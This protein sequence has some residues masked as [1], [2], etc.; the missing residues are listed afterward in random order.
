MKP[1]NIL[2]IE[3]LPD[4][5]RDKDDVILH[6][7]FQLLKN[8]VE[9]EKEIIEIIDWKQDKSTENAKAEIDFLYNWWLERFDKE[10]DL[11]EKQYEEENQM[12]KRLI[13][14]R[15]YLWT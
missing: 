11:D 3:S 15:K 13:D 5:W 8:F 9:Q 4:G 12:L 14:I 10:D 1:A 7:C 6:A 2:K